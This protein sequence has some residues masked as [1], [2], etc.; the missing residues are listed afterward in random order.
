MPRLW[1]CEGEVM[2]DIAFEEWEA[3]QLLDPEFVKALEHLEVGYQIAQ[4]RM[5]RG[6]SQTELGRKA[7]SSGRRIAQLEVGKREP[8]LPFLRHILRALDARLELRCIPN[9]NA[10]VIESLVPD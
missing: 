10:F 7:G 5:L 4:L 2:A 8:G 1:L 3:E 6:L 9:D